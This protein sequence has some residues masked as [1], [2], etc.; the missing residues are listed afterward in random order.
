LLQIAGCQTGKLEQNSAKVSG[1]SGNIRLPYELKKSTSKEVDFLVVL[2][3]HFQLPFSYFSFG[4][5][6]WGF[7]EISSSLKTIFNT[8]FRR[9]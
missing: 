3:S 5:F 2:I 7:F 4:N 1:K 9:I 8:S 6:F